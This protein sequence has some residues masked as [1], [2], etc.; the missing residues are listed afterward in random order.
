TPSSKPLSLERGGPLSFDEVVHV[1]AGVEAKWAAAVNSGT[2]VHREV[3][4]SAKKSAK[5]NSF[6]AA[7]DLRIRRSNPLPHSWNSWLE[8]SATNSTNKHEV[9][10]YSYRRAVMGSIRVPRQA[11]MKPANNATTHSRRET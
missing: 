7:K 3:A 9:V 8:K 1:I 4:K 6:Q 11:G 5:K 2:D 10:S